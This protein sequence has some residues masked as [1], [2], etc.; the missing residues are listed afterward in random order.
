MHTNSSLGRLHKSR[1]GVPELLDDAISY[2]DQ[3]TKRQFDSDS[4][5]GLVRIG[6]RRASDPKLG[7]RGGYLKLTRFVSIYL[8]LSIPRL[9]SIIRDQLQEMY[10]FSIREA[11]EAIKEQLKGCENIL[12]VIYF[13]YRFDSES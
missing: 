8:K 5:S 4:D 1:F 6:D 10:E 12:M 2:F 11:I 13:I 7:I 3:F 9:I